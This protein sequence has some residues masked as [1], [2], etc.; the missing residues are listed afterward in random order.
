MSIIQW[1]A[2]SCCN[3][4]IDIYMARTSNNKVIVTCKLCRYWHV[5]NWTW[6]VAYGV[7]GE[8]SRRVISIVACCHSAKLCAHAARAFRSHRAIYG[9]GRLKRVAWG[10]RSL[11][12]FEICYLPINVLAKNVVRLISRFSKMKFH[13]CWL[14][15]E[16]Y[17]RK[18]SFDHPWNIPL[19][20][21]SYKN[22]WR[23]SLWCGYFL[24]TAAQTHL[25]LGD[26]QVPVIARNE[27]LTNLIVILNQIWC[28]VSCYELGLLVVEA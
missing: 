28:L 23:S 21:P 12:D 26:G 13:H 20:P 17:H 4:H 10:G 1:V 11:M 27:N 16:I 7:R 19:L 2:S 22:P 5:N 18:K 14:P 6:H 8:W 24:R 25:A 3:T 15:N 9:H